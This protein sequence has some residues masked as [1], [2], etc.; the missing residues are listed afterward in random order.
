MN[1][2]TLFIIAVSLSMDSMASSIGMTACL[3]ERLFK[4][5][6]KISLSLSITQSLMTVLGWILGDNLYEIIKPVDH[7]V[8]LSLLLFVGLRMI[9]EGIKDGEI[10]IKHF[11]KSLIFLVLISIATSIDAFAVGFSLS[12]VGI[13]II[14]PAIV[15][16]LVTLFITFTSGSI[17]SSFLKKFEKV[18]IILGGSVLI[19]IGFTIFIEHTIKNI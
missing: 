5:I 19:I 9:Y 13:S 18:S 8:A 16:F 7:W 10:K 12:I 4:D 11:S 2:L 3:K 1:P 15:I 17:S 6:V 14:F